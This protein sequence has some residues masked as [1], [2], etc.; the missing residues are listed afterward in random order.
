MQ[1]DIVP[2]IQCIVELHWLGVDLFWW[3]SHSVVRSRERCV[4]SL[5]NARIAGI[6]L[7]LQLTGSIP[8][9]I[10]QLTALTTLYVFVLT[11]TVS[12]LTLLAS[13]AGIF[14]ATS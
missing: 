2:A 1:R 12:E 13:H 3:Q 10:G 6:F 7:G 9:T 5:T 8:S 14:T 11:I 4:V